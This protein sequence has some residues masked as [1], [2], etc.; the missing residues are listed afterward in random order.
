MNRRNAT[1]ED[2]LKLVQQLSPSEQAR[3]I[4]RI[5]PDIERELV[6]GRPASGVSLLGLVKDLGPAP[7]TD[8][9]DACRRE[10]WAT[11]PRDDT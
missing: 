5:V 11:F 9:I 4:R 1:F 3:L 6:A 8:E 7:S 2:V 10:A